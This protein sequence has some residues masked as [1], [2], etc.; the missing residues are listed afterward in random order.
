[1]K[2][3]ELVLLIDPSLGDS[4]RQDLVKDVEKMLWKGILQKDEIWLLNLAMPVGGRKGKDRAYFVS[5]YLESEWSA[6]Q[7]LKN[8]LAF[9]KGLLRYVFFVLDNRPYLTYA[10]VQKKLEK[11]LEVPVIAEK[12]IKPEQKLE[13]KKEDADVE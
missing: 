12:T 7:W 3:Y 11:L 5:F 2:K 4:D 6:I 1:M 10:D 13:S 8:Q 9:V